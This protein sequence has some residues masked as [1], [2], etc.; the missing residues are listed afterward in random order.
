MFVWEDSG[1][2]SFLMA[3]NFAK[4]H[5]AKLTSMRQGMGRGSVNG[6]MLDRGRDPV[7]HFRLWVFT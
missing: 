4:K 7:H 6:N 1:I 5:A 2:P 3:F